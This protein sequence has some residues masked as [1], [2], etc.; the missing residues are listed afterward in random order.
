MLKAA[1]GTGVVEAVDATEGAVGYAALP[2]IAVKD[3][4]LWGTMILVILLCGPGKI[5]LDYLIERRLRYDRA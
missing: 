5:S 1:G 4:I 2:D 3:H